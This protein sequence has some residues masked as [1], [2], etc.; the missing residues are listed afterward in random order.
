M[1]DSGECYISA[2][3]ESGLDTGGSAVGGAERGIADSIEKGLIAW[4]I[5]EGRGAKS[6]PLDQRYEKGGSPSFDYSRT[7]FECSI[8]EGCSDREDRN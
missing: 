6:N 1:R 7:V 5:A 2:H 3:A 8:K 4:R